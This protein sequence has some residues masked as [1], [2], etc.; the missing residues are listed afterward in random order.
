MIFLLGL[1][2]EDII[3]EYDLAIHGSS[4]GGI[5]FEEEIGEGCD[6]RLLLGVLIPR[7]ELWTSCLELILEFHGFLF[8]A[9]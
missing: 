2:K 9:T 8:D 3:Q 5:T 7:A 1:L 6:R 4:R